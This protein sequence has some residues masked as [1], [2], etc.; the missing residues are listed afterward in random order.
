MDINIEKLLSPIGVEMSDY[1]GFSTFSHCYYPYPD[2]IGVFIP[3]YQKNNKCDHSNTAKRIFSKKNAINGYYRWLSKYL[4]DIFSLLFPD[5]YIFSVRCIKIP[6]N[7]RIETLANGYLK[8]N[9]MND[10]YQ[11]PSSWLFDLF[12]LLSQHIRTS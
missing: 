7:M 5:S 9:A 8:K 10:C 2:T 1:M 11:C 6:T 12:P 4:L 3:V